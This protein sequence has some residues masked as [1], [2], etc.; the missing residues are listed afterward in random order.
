MPQNKRFLRHFYVG[1]GTL[2]EYISFYATER[3]VLQFRN[4]SFCGLYRGRGKAFW[5]AVNYQPPLISIS[6]FAVS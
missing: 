3:F 4:I 2:K 5:V 6:P 1:E